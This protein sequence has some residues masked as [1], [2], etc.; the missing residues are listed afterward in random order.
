MFRK[1]F[2]TFAV[3]LTLTAFSVLTL[4][5]R[6]GR[7]G[8]HHGR[9]HHGGG[10]HGISLTEVL[11]LLELT[12]EL[13]ADQRAEIDATVATL[14]LDA[15]TG[16]EIRVAVVE[17]L[18]AFEVAVPLLLKSKLERQVAALGLTEEQQA[19]VDALIAEHQAAGTDAGETRDAVVALLEELGVE[20]PVY[21]LGHVDRLLLN[22][23]LTEDQV[24]TIKAVVDGLVAE[25]ATKS[26][27][28]AA[29]IA[30]LEAMGVEAPES[31]HAHRG[32]RWGF[33]Y[34]IFDLTDDQRVEILTT[35]T[36]MNTAGAAK[37]EVQAA[38]KALLVEWGIIA[39][40]ADDAAADL[41]IIDGEIQAAPSAAP[42]VNLQLSSWGALKS[43]R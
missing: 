17:H 40:D 19:L 23:E 1:V 16:E 6:S 2:A 9:G 10:H 3:A 18:D 33:S 29:I 34:F 26:E 39:A 12:G 41:A 5:A 4:D 11:D 43:G 31:L 8:S 36:E 27:I 22:L 28:R 7:G 38:V 15:A 13:T 42:S 24:A 25:D 21:L 37:D 30:E 14:T 35:V 32:H 20:V